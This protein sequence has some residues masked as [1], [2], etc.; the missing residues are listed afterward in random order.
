MLHYEFPSILRTYCGTSL[1]ASFFLFCA[2]SLSAA[3]L[4]GKLAGGPASLRMETGKATS[5]ESMAGT[6]MEY[7]KGYGADYKSDVNASTSGRLLAWTVSDCLDKNCKEIVTV[8]LYTSIKENR[9]SV[10]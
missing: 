1:L 5:S 4:P 6:T 9:W 2:A 8:P 10:A 7:L 3:E